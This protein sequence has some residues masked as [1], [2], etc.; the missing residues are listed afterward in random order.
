MNHQCSIDDER[1]PI[2]FEAYEI[3][4]VTFVCLTQSMIGLRSKN[5]D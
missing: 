5:D 3:D 1:Y 4:A 2:S